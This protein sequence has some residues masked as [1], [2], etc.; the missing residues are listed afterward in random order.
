[1][2]Q[3]Q[4][5]TNSLVSTHFRKCDCILHNSLLTIG[6]RS[7]FRALLLLGLGLVVGRKRFT[8]VMCCGEAIW[9]RVICLLH[10]W[11][12]SKPC[13]EIQLKKLGWSKRQGLF[14]QQPTQPLLPPLQHACSNIRWRKSRTPANLWG[15]NLK[16]TEAQDSILCGREN[17]CKWF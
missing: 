15:Q 11:A 16:T 14:I 1:M 17:I 10:L 8:Q 2:Y 7:N 6:S 4:L 5:D 12:Q 3:P 13:L 9:F